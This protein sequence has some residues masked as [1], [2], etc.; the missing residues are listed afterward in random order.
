ML[1]V[2]ASNLG[3]DG[4]PASEVSEPVSEPASDRASEVSAEPV[5][6]EAASGKVDSSEAASSD[7]ASDEA[8]PLP[9]AVTDLSIV[10]RR[11]HIAGPAGHTYA[12]HCNYYNCFLQ[13]SLLSN[14]QLGMEEVLVDTASMLFFITF[15]RT[16]RANRTWCEETRLRFV[17]AFFRKRGYGNPGMLAV[18]DQQTITAT[19]SHYSRGYHAQFGEQDGPRDFFLTGAI[20][21]AL[22]ATYGCDVEVVQ[23]Q[24]LSMGDDRNTWAIRRHPSETEQVRG[25]LDDAQRLKAGRTEIQAA[26]LPSNLPAP[27]VTRAVANMDLSGDDDEGLISAFN[28]ELTFIPSLYYNICSRVFLERLGENTMSADLGRRLLK[29]AGHFSGVYLLGN[30]LQSSEFEILC[31]SHFGADPTEHESMTAL[32]GVINALGW[33]AWTL[34]Y[35]D[36]AELRFTVYNSYEA[37]NVREYYGIADDPVCFL[38]TGGGE[39]IMNALRHADILDHSGPMDTGYVN[40]VFDED[41]GFEAL[42][43]HCFAAGGL[44][45]ACTV[46]VSAPA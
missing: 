3:S 1:S 29:E 31:N 40:H 33:G 34:D 22:M 4:A 38:L 16:F 11:G 14:G 20:R 21:G 17:Q 43:T 26:S 39:S 13:K 5:S 7:A 44:G 35:L 42:E 45:D 23:R 32:F 10:E 6:P 27:P 2:N 9:D 12:A 30:I 24:C 37:Y 46:R 18:M 19:A 25:Y 36:E 28:V 41:D 8:S 15:A